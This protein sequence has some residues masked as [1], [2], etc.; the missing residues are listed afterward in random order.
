MFS[1]TCRWAKYIS[2]KKVLAYKAGHSYASSYGIKLILSNQNRMKF[3]ST[4]GQ[5]LGTNLVM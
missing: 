5:A 4:K 3:N 2:E 1:R